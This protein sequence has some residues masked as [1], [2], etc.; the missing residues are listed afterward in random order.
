MMLLAAAAGGSLPGSEVLNK[1]GAVDDN[2][3]DKGGKL[4]FNGTFLPELVFC[5]V[6]TAA[7]Q[8][9]WLHVFP[10]ANP[11][12]VSIIT[13]AISYAGMQTATGP[14]LPWGAN[15]ERSMSKPRK[16]TPL[17]NWISDKLGF[18]RGDK[19]YCRT[20]MAFKGFIIGLPI[21]GVPLAIL[22]PL[23]FEIGHRV[24]PYLNFDPQLAKDALTGLGTATAIS[25]F[26]AIVGL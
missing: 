13:L 2:G 12:L 5:S 26:L 19:N 16:L 14:A 21:G 17:V 8:Q 15:P 3:N 4:P 22:W 7:A 11:V 18:E 20:W 9:G 24:T 10:N 6:I 1:R 25:L 23:G